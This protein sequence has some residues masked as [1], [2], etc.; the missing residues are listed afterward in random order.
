MKNY[1]TENDRWQA[2]LAR[3][4]HAD[5]IFF[6]AVLSTGI[7]CYPSC[8]SRQA[9]RE[10]VSFYDNAASAVKSGYKP[11]KR[12]CSDKA[13]P[14]QRQRELVISA[15]Q[16]LDNEHADTRIEQVASS[17]NISRFH[18][19]KLFIKFLGISPKAYAM[20]ARNARVTSALQQ[21]SSVTKALFDAGYESPSSFYRDAA[22]RL[23]MSVKQLR[24]GASSVQIQYG[25]T[26]TRYGKI[27]VGVTAKGV[28]AVLFGT[29]RKSLCTDLQRRFPNATLLGHSQE[30]EQLLE[31]V[32]QCIEQHKVSKSI[33]LD[34]QGTVFQEKVW[35]ALRDSSSGERFSYSQLA[36]AIGQPKAARAV[37]S[38]C[39]AN[40]IAVLI[41]CHRVVRGDG[42][43]SGYRWGIERKE[44]LLKDES[45]EFANQ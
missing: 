13:P 27:I 31:Q 9:K 36:S 14:L 8:A 32:V 45:R 37:A 23:G 42:S 44:Q 35:A 38:A 43:L 24:Q 15:C 39:A 12:C 28:C 26:S 1:K 20:A 29:S 18:L 3:D 6:Y 17:L 41:P 21:S 11:C 7:Y 22:S 5:G 33:P 40:P 34:I 16:L 10:N 25:F 4:S 19:Q 30:L 2:V